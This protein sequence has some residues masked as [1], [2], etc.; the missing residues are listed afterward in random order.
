MDATDYALNYLADG[1]TDIESFQRGFAD[2]GRMGLNGE[3]AGITGPAAQAAYSAGV[4]KAAEH[5]E[6]QA[7]MFPDVAQA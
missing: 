5:R 2:S 1:G 3:L 6:R 7:A 4:V